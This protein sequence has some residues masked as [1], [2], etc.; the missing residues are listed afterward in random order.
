M[1][2]HIFNLFKNISHWY[3]NSL[4]FKSWVILCGILQVPTKLFTHQWGPK[5][6]SLV[7][8]FS[9]ASKLYPNQSSDFFIP[10]TIQIQNTWNS[11]KLFLLLEKSFSISCISVPKPSYLIQNLW[12]HPGHLQPLKPFR[13]QYW[14]ILSLPH[15]NLLFPIQRHYFSLHCRHI[16]CRQIYY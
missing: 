6:L 5:L 15:L 12:N 2:F 10:K 1:S 11:I 8:V 13:Y 16:S 4:V 14:L 7:P 3:L 9:L